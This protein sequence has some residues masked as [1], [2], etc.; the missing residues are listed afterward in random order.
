MTVKFISTQKNTLYVK[1]N[2]KN[3]KIIFIGCIL[4]S[5]II[6]LNPSIPALEYNQIKNNQ[7][8][9]NTFIIYRIDILANEILILILNIIITILEIFFIIPLFIVEDLID[10][11]WELIAQIED[12]FIN[13]ICTFFNMIIESLWYICLGFYFPIIL[14]VYILDIIRDSIDSNSLSLN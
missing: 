11:I 13:T 2:I 5:L 14:L 7:I 12:P 6:I 3:T 4:I 8:N 1:F 10:T 9:E